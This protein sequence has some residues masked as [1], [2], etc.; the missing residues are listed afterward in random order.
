MKHENL[1]QV[2]VDTREQGT[3]VVGPAMIRPCCELLAR[4]IA[5]EVRAGRERTWSNPQILE[6]PQI[7]H[8]REPGDADGRALN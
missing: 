7:I 8:K 6:I 4:T 1:C 3:I 5:R 2:M